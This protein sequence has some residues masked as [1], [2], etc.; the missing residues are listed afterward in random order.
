[1]QPTFQ[2]SHKGQQAHKVAAVI[3]ALLCFFFLINMDYLIIV[4]RTTV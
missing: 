2:D 3:L 1:M 4:V